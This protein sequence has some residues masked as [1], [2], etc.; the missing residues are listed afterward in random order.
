MI[1]KKESI[2]LLKSRVDI[3]DL[4]GSYLQLRRSG[5]NYMACCPFHEERTAS[6][7]V[8]QKGFYYCFGCQAKG[9]AIRFV[10]EVEKISFG[11]AAQK[12]AD[13]YNITLEYEQGSAA[14]KRDYRPLEALRDFYKREL[15]RSSEAREY[16]ANRSLGEAAIERFEVGYAP[17][18][19]PQIDFLRAEKIGFDTAIEAG[20][21]VLDDN[22]RY[23]ARFTKRITF[24]I[25][26]HSGS[27]VG[28]GGRTIS[29][30]PAKYINSPQSEFFDKSRVLYALPIAR[31]H[32]L[33]QKTAIVCEGYM[34]AAM[35]HQAGF[36]NAI[37]TLGT[38][39][40]KEHLPL[41][42]RLDNPKIIL[43]YDS[44][45]A[46]REAALKAAKLLSAHNFSGGVAIFG[47]GKDPADLVASGSAGS[48]VKAYE[49][50]VPFTK[51]A[52]EA[53]IDRAANPDAAFESAGEYLATLSEL[54]FE[55]ARGYAAAKL[56][57]DERRFKRG[58][59]RDTGRAA[60]LLSG[61]NDIGELQI[62]K[63]LVS[64]REL[65]AAL[66]D[67]LDERL[68]T[69]HKELFR[70]L[71]SDDQSALYPLIGE[72][73][74]GVLSGEDAREALR[75]LLV[76]H[77]ERELKK[78][79]ANNERVKMREAARALSELKG[80]SLLPFRVF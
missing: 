45:T 17:E 2:E 62:I 75:R 74:I 79:R 35:L 3:V 80:G 67:Y 22:G 58:A 56:G 59:V 77:F 38:A 43:S 76:I 16:L 19:A 12:I 21:L 78:L 37:A 57:V 41:L 29:D 36:Q 46:G 26:S 23:Y 27:L 9:D 1:I 18:N 61:K 44:D 40:T 13:L 31:E 50:L 34:D 25:Y 39:L 64:D 47:G 10:Q 28:F 63:T 30:H 11:E 6:F 73:R 15:M 71:Y 8:N 53:I 69:A 7:S 14:K 66:I 49:S 20:V 70:A 72:D 5:A 60:S 54:A 24:P 51:Y 65:F 32:I 55:G 42:K 52:L 68:F 33:K 4:V 48:L